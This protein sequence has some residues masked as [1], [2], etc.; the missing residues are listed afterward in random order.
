MASEA[1]AAE[2]L[3]KVVSYK[4]NEATSYPWWAIVSTG[5]FGRPVIWAGPWFSREAATAYLNAKH[6][7]FPK[8]VHVF[9]FSGHESG[10][11]RALVDAA[12]EARHAR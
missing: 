4:D 8:S 12:K 9:C 5:S 3:S 6:Y 7:N 10:D 1:K 2:A 11:F